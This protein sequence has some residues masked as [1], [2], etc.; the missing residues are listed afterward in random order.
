MTA[1]GG[2]RSFGAPRFDVVLRGYD[3]R[4]VD[5][6]LSRLQRVMGRMRSDLDARPCPAG[7]GRRAPDPGGRPSAPD[8]AA[9]SD[10][11]PPTGA[12]DVVGTFTDRMQSDP[13]GRRGGGRGDPRRPAR[14]PGR[15]GKGRWSP[16]RHARGGGDGPRD[17]RGP[18]APARRGAGRAHPDARPARRA[19]VRSDDADPGADPEC[20]PDRREA[21]A[22]QPLPGTPAP[23]SG[24]LTRPGPRGGAGR[25]QHRVEA[26]ARRPGTATGTAVFAVPLGARRPVTAEPDAPAAER[27]SAG[28]RRRVH[29]PRRPRM[30]R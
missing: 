5:E 8:P 26:P 4:Q 13:A 6:H 17:A 29:R 11:S 10:G 30:S 25:G 7:A 3:R 24:P 20:G 2:D 19:A 22:G 18:R 28:S 9:A 14:G 15:R 21:G 27:T 16:G 23:P 12:H 1:D